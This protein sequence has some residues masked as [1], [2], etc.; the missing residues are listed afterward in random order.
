MGLR[1]QWREKVKER[2]VAGGMVQPK[3]FA[4]AKLALGVVLTLSR[5][6]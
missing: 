5:D 3:R 2:W 6:F 4:G 1:W